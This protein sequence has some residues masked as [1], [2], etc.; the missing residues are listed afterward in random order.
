MA[1]EIDNPQP[2]P[3][4]PLHPLPQNPL[5]APRQCRYIKA[6]GEPCRGRATRGHHY[7]QSHTLNRQPTFAGVK[8]C[9]RV[10]FLEDTASIQL[11]ASQILN[12]LLD[13]IVE[14]ERARAT[15]ALLNVANT[16]LRDL[17]VHERW[18]LQNKHP[19]PEQVGETTPVES[20]PLG[21]DHSWVRP[22]DA[23]EPQA[24]LSRNRCEQEGEHL[25]PPDPTSADSSASDWLTEDETME[26]DDNAIAH[27]CQAELAELEKNRAAL[28]DGLPDSHDEPTLPDRHCPFSIDGCEGLAHPHRCGYCKGELAMTPSDSRHPG[29]KVIAKIVQLR[30]QLKQKEELQRPDQAPTSAT[31]NLSPVTSSELASATRNPSP[32]T[33]NP[34]LATSSDPRHLGQTENEPAG[35]SEESTTKSGLDLQA[36]AIPDRETPNANQLAA[37]GTCLSPVSSLLSP[38]KYPLPNG[39]PQSPQNKR[40]ARPPSPSQGAQAP[41]YTS[42]RPHPPIEALPTPQSQCGERMTKK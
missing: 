1:Q 21:P 34:P 33:H 35:E 17:R 24:V 15:A 10:A 13:R 29:E 7:C 37:P 12:G 42:P 30:E 11:A 6:S 3:E 27:R 25:G 41:Q 19:L 20:E 18:L 39:T 16:A 26:R 38:A 32:V 9:D 2:A 28:E 4:P 22:I 8:G 36:V 23:L 31:C 5:N 40:P 14:P